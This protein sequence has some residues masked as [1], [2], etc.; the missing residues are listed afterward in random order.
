MIACISGRRGQNGYGMSSGSA[1]VVI[2]NLAWF[3][4]W[5]ALVA[6][7]TVF[8]AR[9]RRFT[10]FRQ[11]MLAAWPPALVLALL[12]LAGRIAF[13]LPTSDVVKLVGSMLL[14]IT[15]FA[16]A[17]IGLALA[18]G[19]PK[20]D[21]LPITT[22]LAQRRRVLRTVGLTL[23]IVVAAAPVALVLG[24]LGISLGAGIAHE[25][26][27]HSAAA[28]QLPANRAVLFLVLLAGAGIAEEV[29]YRLVVLSLVWRITGNPWI[30]VIVAVVLH[31]LYHLTPLNAFYTTFWQYPVAQVLSSVFVG[32]VFGWLYVKRGLE[33]T[34]LAHTVSDWIG[35]AFL[36]S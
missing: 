5:I 31:G 7:I 27:R 9:S 32:L 10:D 15:V 4:A 8:G 2:T 33:S 34:V 11:R 26:V 24:S 16:Q 21:P 29:A 30:G 36:L 12:T 19:I 22:A 14:P 35:V 28:S 23:L 6:A 13:G 20:Y 18:R 25:T 17:L 3:A 1:E